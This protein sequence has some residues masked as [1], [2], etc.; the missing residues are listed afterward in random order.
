MNMSM[1]MN[2][3]VEFLLLENNGQWLS[4][5]LSSLSRIYQQHERVLVISSQRQ[6]LEQLDEILWH[7]SGEQFIPYSLD[8]E[9]YAN[10]TAVLLTDKQPERLRFKALLN[11]SGTALKSPEQFKTIIEI[12]QVDEEEKETARERYKLYR[13]LGFNISHRTVNTT[14]VL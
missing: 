13:H 12:V 7:N 9:C 1:L 4:S 8:S 6:K 10:S 2:T 5:T 3:Q 11:L 14:D